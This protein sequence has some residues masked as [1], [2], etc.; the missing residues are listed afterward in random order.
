MC[1]GNILRR[2]FDL[3][4]VWCLIVSIHD[5]RLLSYFVTFDICLA[6]YDLSCDFVLFSGA[7]L[8]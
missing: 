3:G 5:L 2:H 4:L 1:F 6:I 8:K 7:K